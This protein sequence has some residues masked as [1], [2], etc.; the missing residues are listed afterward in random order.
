M[1]SHFRQHREQFDQLARILNDGINESSS[2]QYRSLLQQTGLT[3]VPERLPTR[4]IHF[5][6]WK[7]AC[8]YSGERGYVYAQ[9]PPVA[10]RERCK[11]QQLVDDWYTYHFMDPIDSG[12][13]SCIQTGRASTS[14]ITAARYFV[15]TAES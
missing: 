14:A 4:T 1:E 5:R 2:Q 10:R 3:R 12:P 15:L 7:H 11:Y 6:Y 9:K 8:S 13:Q